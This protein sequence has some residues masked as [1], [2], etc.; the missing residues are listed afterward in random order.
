MR[1]SLRDYLQEQEAAAKAAPKTL[2]P[3]KPRRIDRRL[4]LL[5]QDGRKALALRAQGV[6]P[7]AILAIIGGS[8]A[9]M[10]KAMY[11]AEAAIDP[12]LL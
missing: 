11:A 4:T 1:E 8:R 9:R 2:S 10:Y 6:K 12:L 3:S 5:I 7:S